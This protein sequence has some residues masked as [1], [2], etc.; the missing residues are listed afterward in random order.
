[1]TK[2]FMV[3]VDK[4]NLSL[5]DIEK[6]TLNSMKSAFI[7]YKKRLDFIYK[8]IKPGFQSMREK[9][10]SLKSATT[11]EETIHKL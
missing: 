11:N 3:A 10:L 9:L 7:P 5:E 8:I 6:I 2:E 4:F 1:M